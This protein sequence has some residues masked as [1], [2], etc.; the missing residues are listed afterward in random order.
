M[1]KHFDEAQVI[2]F[3]ASEQSA[4]VNGASIAV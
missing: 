3:L 4:A 1:R 2:G